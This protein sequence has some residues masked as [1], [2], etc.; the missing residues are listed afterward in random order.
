MTAALGLLA[1]VLGLA[2]AMLFRRTRRLARER[3][4]TRALT[5]RYADAATHELHT[6]LTAIL[7][8]QELLA[9]GV[10]GPLEPPAADAV[11]RIGRAAR[12]LI[13]LVDGLV[14][15]V[16]L[17]AGPVELQRR[18]VPLADV[19]SDTLDDAR[20]LATER[21]GSVEGEIPDGLPVVDTDPDR[22]RRALGLAVM[23]AVRASGRRDL[24]VRFHAA[25]GAAE[26]AVAGTGVPPDVLH[27]GPGGNEDHLSLRLVVAARLARALG[28]DVVVEPTAPDASTVRV[29]IAS[30]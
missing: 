23:A 19:F 1:S 13:Y 14:D 24:H 2:A 16:I 21:G 5:H 30:D 11:D 27:R 22:L 17:D 9:D 3:D 7:G 8:Y 10:Y 15:T 4:R 29:R 25:D 6:P 12:Q 18:P 26:M 20:A 28:G